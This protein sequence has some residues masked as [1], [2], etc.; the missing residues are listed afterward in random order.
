MKFL[1]ASIAAALSALSMSHA[2]T[3]VVDVDSLPSDNGV[4]VSLDAGVYEL[5]FVEGA[6]KAWNAWGKVQGCDSDG[7]NCSKGWLT[8]INVLAEG[9]VYKLGRHG[10]FE[11]PDLA[12]AAA[13]PFTLTLSALT[14]VT[15]YIGDSYF[16]DNV[17]G[18][19]MQVA[20]IA[21]PVPAAGLLFV[22]AAAGFAVARRRR[23]VA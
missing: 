4:T 1:I 18:I 10:R 11:T 9:T 13:S 19:S 23:M 8:N 3:M 5:S 14:D 21:M 20:A 6:Y 15:F 22:G 17:G 2:A 12:L 7:A 16:K